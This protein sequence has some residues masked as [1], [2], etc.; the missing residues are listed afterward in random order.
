MKLWIKYGLLNALIGLLI[1]IL[2]AL[3]AIGSGYYIFIIAAPIS[4]FLVGGFFWKFIIHE[5]KQ[6]V[7]GRIILTGFLTGTVSHYFTFVITSIILNISY[8]TTGSYLGSL[9]E[10][11]ASIFDML[12]GAFAFSFFSLLFFGW[13]TV[14]VSILTG[15]LIKG[16]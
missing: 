7:T 13:I 9:G 5:K 6:S 3:K 15:F 2:V 1:G 16:K 14:P 8:W 11:P 12:T 10:K 4:A